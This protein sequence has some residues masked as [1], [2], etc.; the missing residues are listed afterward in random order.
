MIPSHDIESENNESITI[1]LDEDINYTIDNE[2]H[3][4]VDNIM[5]GFYDDIDNQ[6]IGMKKMLHLLVNQLSKQGS[7]NVF[8][9][10][11]TPKVKNNVEQVVNEYLTFVK[12]LIVIKTTS[13]YCIG[14]KEAK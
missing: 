3:L 12:A 5:Y 4:D 14:P 2:L 10:K 11:P 6:Q 8:K 7:Q 13:K 9:I 1:C